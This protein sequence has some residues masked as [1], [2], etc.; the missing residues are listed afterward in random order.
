[1]LYI[2][3]LPWCINLRLFLVHASSPTVKTG[4]VEGLVDYKILTSR[5]SM[6]RAE[7]DE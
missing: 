6:K 3:I 7:T 1:M 5:K 4:T 2:F